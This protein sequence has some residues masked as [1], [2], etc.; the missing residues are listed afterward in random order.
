MAGLI[1]SLFKG[2]KTRKEQKDE[3][4]ANEEDYLVFQS[5]S[6]S[7][8][9]PTARFADDCMLPATAAYHTTNA[10]KLRKGPQ[11]CPGGNRDDDNNFQKRKP[12]DHHEDFRIDDYSAGRRQYQSHRDL[13]HHHS[14]RRKESKKRNSVFDFRADD[15]SD[16]DENDENEENYKKNYENADRHRRE[17]RRK[18]EKWEEEKKSIQNAM[19][20]MAFC[21]ASVQQMEQLK[22]E[23]DQYKKEANRYKNRCEKL[24]N[25]FEQMG[26]MSPNYA[27]LQALSMQPSPY[28]TPQFPQPQFSQPLSFQYPMGSSIQTFAQPPNPS[29]STRSVDFLNHQ[30]RM[31]PQLSF[32]QQYSGALSKNTHGGSTSFTTSG[33]PTTIGSEG[34]GE[35]LVNPSDLSFLG[36]YQFKVPQNYEESCD[37][38]EVKNYRHEEM[39]FPPSRLSDLTVSTAT[40][41]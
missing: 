1:R 13:S 10:P 31:P 39:F 17:E 28:Q 18:Q 38:D 3:T 5:C 15:R 16:D 14:L 40:T 4:A 34:A 6:G 33:T 24:E 23:R 9:Q 29:V 37:E 26:T 30:G 8:R 19:A 22:K 35:S 2:K 20:N 21:M 11:S 25:K 32:P 41:N 36:D 27:G 12:R 7:K